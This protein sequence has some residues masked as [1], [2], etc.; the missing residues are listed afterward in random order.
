MFQQRVEATVRRFRA[1]FARLRHDRSGSV[2]IYTALIV[3]VIVG[4]SGLAIDVGVW[5]A[6]GRQ[7]R[8]AV[9]SAARAG[10]LEVLRSDS[11]PVKIEA[12]VRQDLSTYGYSA[13]AGD[14][15]IVRYPPATGPHAGA[16]DAV[17]VIIASPTDRYFSSV[18][19]QTDPNVSA[20]AVAVADINDTCIWSLNPSV[21]SAINISGSATASLGCGVFVNSSN[22]TALNEGGS[23][24]LNS[25]K[26]KVVG[27][28]SG[29][30]LT[31]QPL[32]GAAPITDPMASLEGPLY[33]PADCDNTNYL[34]N[35]GETLT[36]TPGTYC[37]RIKVVSDGTLI[38]EP[39][40]YILGDRGILEIGGNATVTGDGVSFYLTADNSEELSITGGASIE[41]TAPP[42]GPLP[43]ILFYHD[44]NT[45]DDI[46][47]KITGGSNMDLEGIIYL[48]SQ[49]LQFA[50]GS[51]F[52]SST[53]LLIADTVSLTGN[54]NIGD[55]E[56]SPILAN[57]LL[58]SATLVE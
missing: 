34:V 15:V 28:Y 32:T 3:P 54:S 27:G 31:P 23:G 21:P 1:G 24:C 36:L 47:H 14:T 22:A 46:T 44:R 49:S 37:R 11:D 8:T 57:P 5:Y 17:E 53:S 9:D 6:E 12:A 50:G 29:D 18:F 38:L 2:I 26:I 55:F 43:G 58:I 45:T 40:L 48:P 19:L 41:L 7:T 16:G 51:E 42:D 52:N 4:L 35:S 13:A 56:N 20:R 30:C 39:G 10:A 33:N 25:T